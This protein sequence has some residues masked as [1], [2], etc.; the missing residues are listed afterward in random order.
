MKSTM[1]F[2]EILG[3]KQNATEEEI[4]LAYKKQMKKWH[5]DINKDPNAINMSS[6][7]NEAKE[8]LL[9]SIKRRDYDEYLQVMKGLK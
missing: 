8:V 6:K 1:N 9:D 7:I 4:K 5:P 2:Y 3:V